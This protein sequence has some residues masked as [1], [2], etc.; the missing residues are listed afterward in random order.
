MA[1]KYRADYS[2]E[3]DNGSVLWFTRWMAGSSMAAAGLLGLYA[4]F[5]PLPEPVAVG[6]VW[7]IC[8]A[9]LVIARH[10][11]N[12]RVWVRRRFA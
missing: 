8:I 7:G 9:L 11:H 12:I 6:R 2:Q 4:A 10:Q 5:A 1:Q 3:Q